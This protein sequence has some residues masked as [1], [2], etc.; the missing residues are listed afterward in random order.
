MRTRSHALRLA[1][2]DEDC[3]LHIGSQLDLRDFTRLRACSRL[4]RALKRPACVKDTLPPDPCWEYSDR[5]RLDR[6][7]SPNERLARLVF[8]HDGWDLPDGRWPKLCKDPPTKDDILQLVELGADVDVRLNSGMPLTLKLLEEE[9]DNLR[10]AS[11]PYNPIRFSDH[12]CALGAAIAL[13]AAGADPDVAAPE[14]PGWDEEI[15]T[16]I[17][18]VLAYCVYDWR[19]GHIDEDELSGLNMAERLAEALSA[20]GAD[21]GKAIYSEVAGVTA[22]SVA[23]A[24]ARGILDDHD[25]D[26]DDA[27]WCRKAARRALRILSR[28]C[29]HSCCNI[30]GHD[31]DE[32][33]NDDSDDDDDD[34]D[35]GDDGDGSGDE[36]SG[37]SSARPG[38]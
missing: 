34:D 2:L 19:S 31:D 28:Y 25:D 29:D 20:A 23:H 12:G 38:E 3:L 9:L 36:E 35:S 32:H 18:Y 26:E 6:A 13:L 16:A 24:T 4:F 21:F 1:N 33:D 17:Q 8:P 5:P 15:R 11:V 14:Q 30:P 7:L 22:C 10:E 37:E 27:A